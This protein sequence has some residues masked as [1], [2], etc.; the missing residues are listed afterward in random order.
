MKKSARFECFDFDSSKMAEFS[1]NQPRP[2]LFNKTAH[3]PEHQIGDSWAH[4]HC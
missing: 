3:E 4:A 1:I 2:S